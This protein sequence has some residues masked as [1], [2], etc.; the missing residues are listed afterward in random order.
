MGKTTS[1]TRSKKAQNDRLDTIKKRNG[2]I[3]GFGGGT[4]PVM[5][6]LKVDSAPQETPV[7]YLERLPDEVADTTAAASTAA[8][9]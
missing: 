4:K 8:K 9:V 7:E 3:W 6:Y 5:L 2:R 1:L